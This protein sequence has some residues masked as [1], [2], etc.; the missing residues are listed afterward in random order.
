MFNKYLYPPSIGIDMTLT[1][2]SRTTVNLSM[3]SIKTSFFL[4]S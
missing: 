1:S 2:V 4:I 3:M